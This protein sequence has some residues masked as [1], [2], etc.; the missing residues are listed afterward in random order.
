M[1]PWLLRRI[2]TS[3]VLVFVLTSAVFFIVRLAPGDPLHQM[4]A[5]ETQAVDRELLRE[6]LGLQGSL[7][8]QYLRWLGGLLRGDLGVSLRQQRPVSEIL[9]EAVGPTLLL[10]VTAYVGHLLLA[11][12]VATGMVAR[13]GR[14]PDHL[15]QATGLTLY[16]LPSFWLGLMLIMLFAGQLGWLPVGGMRAPDAAFLSPVGRLL[17]LLRHLILPVAT[18][19]LGSFM[20][21]ARHLRASLEEVL[22]QDYI[23]AA[24][25][26]GLDEG[27]ILRRHALRNALLPVATLVGLHLPFILGG[28]V[29]VEVV[30]GWPGMGRV[31]VEAHWARDYPVN[32][33]T[34][35]LS[36]LA[37]VA[38]SLLADLLYRRI[39]PRVRTGGGSAR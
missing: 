23:V 27:V 36:S 11:V 37:V 26:R 39:D 12:L 5:E 28:A 33:A 2:A 30:F 29:V 20:G 8:A 1:F 17:D 16:S 34:T 14:F 25:A 6:R 22:D 19:A 15:L 32:V 13:R 38:G 21:T 9:G 4:V 3:L 24:R 10:T 7:G 18:L 35:L 31:T